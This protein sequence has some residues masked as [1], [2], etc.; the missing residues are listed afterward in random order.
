MV[1]IA[2]IVRLTTQLSRLPGIGQK[3]AQRL[4]YHI[5]DVPEAQALSS[6]PVA[7]DHA[8]T[9]ITLPAPKPIAIPVPEF[10]HL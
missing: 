9:S 10:I 5:L 7:P 3:T 2:S 6:D 1:T 4:A 8:D